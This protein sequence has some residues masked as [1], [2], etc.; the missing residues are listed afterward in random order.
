MTFMAGGRKEDLKKAEP[1]LKIMGKNIFH[2]GESPGAGQSVKIC[3]N[4]LLAV[5]MIGTCEAFALG[6]ALGLHPE[7]LNQ[8]YEV[9]FR[10]QLVFG[11][12]QPLPW[13]NGVGPLIKGL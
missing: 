11:K 10:Q 1:L 9:Q 12:I 13:T 4:M 6:K 3:N 5:H 7:T 2:A 8:N